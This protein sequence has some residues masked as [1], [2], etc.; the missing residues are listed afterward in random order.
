MLDVARASTD[1][2]TRTWPRCSP[3]SGNVSLH[4]PAKAEPSRPAGTRAAESEQAGTW[5]R[6]PGLPRSLLI[7]SVY[8]PAHQGS[9]VRP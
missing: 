3:S 9:V 5:G 8:H 4:A 7:H 2:R 6:N 1:P